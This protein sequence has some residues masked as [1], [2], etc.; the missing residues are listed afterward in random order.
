LSWLGECSYSL[1]ILHFPIFVLVNGMLLEKTKNVMPKTQL[2]II[3]FSLIMVVIAY[4][5]HFVIEKPFI[6]KKRKTGLVL[7]N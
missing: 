7:P 2:W 3:F 6:Q 1:Y 4:G 5:I